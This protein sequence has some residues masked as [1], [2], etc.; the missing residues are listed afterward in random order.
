VDNLDV[1]G[2]DLY[3]LFGRDDIAFVN[4]LDSDDATSPAT[5]RAQV[6]FRNS[7]KCM[8][9]FGNPLMYS[10]KGLGI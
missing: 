1:T 2:G 4:F 10:Y 7:E 3:K 9:L 8:L 6:H 5:R